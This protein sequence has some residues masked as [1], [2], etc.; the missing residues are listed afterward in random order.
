MNKATGKKTIV[1]PVI[2]N[3]GRIKDKIIQN[4]FIAECRYGN[5]NGYYNNDKRDRECHGLKV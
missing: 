1:L 5:K 4:F 3:S 2:G